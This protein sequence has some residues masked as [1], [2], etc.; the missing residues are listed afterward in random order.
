[1]W[2]R[3]IATLYWNATERRCVHVGT[4]PSGCPVHQKRRIIGLGAWP[5]V[6]V[7]SNPKM[8]RR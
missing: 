8:W 7:G 5:L 6:E 1:M 2:S 4:A 3:K